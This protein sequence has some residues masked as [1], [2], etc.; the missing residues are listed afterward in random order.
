MLAMSRWSNSES[1]APVSSSVLIAGA[2][3]SDP[4]ET[5]RF[6]VLG[7]ARLGDHPAIADQ[8]HMVEAAA[9][10]ELLDLGGQRDRIGRVAVKHLN[11]DRAAVGGAEQAVGDLQRALPPVSAVSA[12]GERAAT[13]FHV[14]RRN[15]VQHERA[16]DQMAFGQS[17]LDGG[18]T[19]QQPVRRGVEF[20][21]VDL[22]EAECFA[23]A[24]GGRGGRQRTSGGELGC[25]LEDPAD[26]E[27]EDKVAAAIAVGAKD[28]VKTYPAGGAES[29]GD[30]AGRVRVTVT[31]SRSAGMTVPPL[32]TPRRPSTWAAGQSERLQRVRLRTLP[33]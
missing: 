25:G 21:L 14:A 4:I 31:A 2:Q 16:V 1:K 10:L 12:L 20:G 15:V 13:P 32:S 27:S 24:R 22:A 30:V 9:L 19:L 3:R 33:S 26:E 8:D 11:G 23:K 18:L 7:D 28:T 17:G 29:G 6:D 5:C